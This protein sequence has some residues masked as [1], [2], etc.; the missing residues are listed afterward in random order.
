MAANADIL[1][2][3]VAPAFEALTCL[4]VIFERPASVVIAGVPKVTAGP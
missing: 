3:T 2:G 1:A 4:S